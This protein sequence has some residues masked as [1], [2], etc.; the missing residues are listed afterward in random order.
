MNEAT[1]LSVLFLVAGIYFSVRNVRMLRNETAL[2]EYMQSSP[3]A[4]LW[5]RK[6]G[7]DDATRLARKFFLPSGLLIS[8][9]MAGVG[10]WNL[11]RM[12]I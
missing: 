6:F 11:W 12:Y 2:R 4:T 5:V 7:L 9:A 1:I 8:V 10:A 3:K